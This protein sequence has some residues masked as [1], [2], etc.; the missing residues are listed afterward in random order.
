MRRRQAPPPAAPPRT[1][2]PPQPQYGRPAGGPGRHDDGYNTG[3]V[4]GGG[5][6]RGGGPQDG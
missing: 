6:G 2:V 3:Q 5:G 4:Y 1:T